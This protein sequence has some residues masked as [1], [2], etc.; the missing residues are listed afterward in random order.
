MKYLVAFVVAI[1]AI[2]L[3]NWLYMPFEQEKALPSS[4]ELLASPTPSP[5]A[6]PNAVAMTK[7]V[8]EIVS[9]WFTKK[10]DK[11]TVR[12]ALCLYNTGKATNDCQYASLSMV[13]MG[14]AQ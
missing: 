2:I 9:T 1:F 4:F 12:Q 14:G 6:T 7:E 10:L 13:M 11:Y 5:V 8:S 3:I